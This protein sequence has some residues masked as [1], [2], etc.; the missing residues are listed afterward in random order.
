[1]K[2]YSIVHFYVNLATKLL[3]H[4]S[5][6]SFTGFTSQ[7][8]ATPFHLQLYCDDIKKRPEKL[9]VTTKVL[10]GSAPVRSHSFPDF[11]GFFGVAL[12]ARHLM[13][14]QAF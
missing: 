7:L 9:N 14:Y 4:C 11:P 1:M 6:Y 3:A 12:S 13:T 10:C 2:L 5:V 8:T